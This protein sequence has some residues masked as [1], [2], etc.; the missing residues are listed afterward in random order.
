ML[1][2]VSITCSMLCN[3]VEPEAMQKKILLC[4][5]CLHA[6]SAQLNISLMRM[7]PM[8]L[9]KIIFCLFF[10]NC[11]V[12]PIPLV[13]AN[14]R[15]VYPFLIT[16]CIGSQLFFTYHISD[17]FCV[18]YYPDNYSAYYFSHSFILKDSG[19]VICS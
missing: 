8:C 11:Y 17:F 10:H 12:H 7:H 14:V 2:A 5:H 18:S 9:I 13:V 4:D 19:L 1:T 16:F 15:I 3:L 6:P